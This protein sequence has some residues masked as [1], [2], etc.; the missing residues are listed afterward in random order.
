MKTLPVRGLLLSTLLMALGILQADRASSQ[1]FSILHSFAGGPVDGNIPEAGL[2]IS[3][4]TLYGTTS[5]G[6]SQL[7]GTI[8]KINTDGSG[9]TLINDF[10]TT[11]GPACGRTPFAGL[12]LSGSTFYGTAA[13]GGTNGDGTVFQVSIGG[14]NLAVLK[15]FGNEPEG[16]APFAGLTLSGSTLYGT[17]EAGGTN[18]YGLVFK[19]NTDGNGYTVLRNFTNSDGANPYGGLILLSNTLYGTTYH[20]GSNGVG[21]VFK[22]N[23]DG[24]GF[25]LLKNFSSF[26]GAELPRAGLVLSGTTLL[27]TTEDS[28]AGSG[29]VFKIDIDGNNYSELWNFTVPI[30]G[31]FPRGGLLLFGNTLYGTT[32]NGGSSTLGTVFKINTDGSGFAVLKRFTGVPDGANPYAGLV[33]AGNTLYGTTE[34]GGDF[35]LGTIFSLALLPSLN[36]AL[37]GPDAIVTWPT[38]WMGYTLQSSTN[39][40]SEVW[41]NVTNGI[42]TTGTNYVSTN[43]VSSNPTFFRLAQ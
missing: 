29:A 36:I 40:S 6:G 43:I 19:V 27:G 41:S 4:N 25:T 24:S 26:N 8:F 22:I 20:G 28:G 5:G 33:L 2:I 10:S 9:Y 18:G 12:I 38:N 14:G 34:K 11:N 3:G 16:A 37:S 1:T 13:D 35:N 31:S 15:V 23:T 42:A 30:N 7:Y 39:L 32:Y 17:A 21:T